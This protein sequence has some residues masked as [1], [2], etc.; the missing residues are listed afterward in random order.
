[1]LDPYGLSDN[2]C[3]VRPAP[4]EKVVEKKLDLPID[5]VG[6]QDDR[7]L[8]LAGYHV[9]V[10]DNIVHV[11][12]AAKG[13]YQGNDLIGTDEIAETDLLTLSTESCC[14]AR[15]VNGATNCVWEGGSHR[16]S[17]SDRD[18]S[19]EGNSVSAAVAIQTTGQGTATL[20]VYV[21]A[22][23]THQ[24]RIRRANPRGI[25]RPGDVFGGH[26]FDVEEV[27]GGRELIAPPGQYS[28]TCECAED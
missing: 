25:D 9:A 23:A 15:E 11:S 5:D 7:L 13:L 8:L 14:V 18:A 27:G 12:A 22:L 2:E 19:G 6:P 3:I 26:I 24:S 17:D 1:L 21:E 28:F 4:F 10:V 20:T 16:I